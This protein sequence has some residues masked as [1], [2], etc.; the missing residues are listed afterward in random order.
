LL[1]QNKSVTDNA[2]TFIKFEMNFSF[3][4]TTL[5]ALISFVTSQTKA[6]VFVY[7]D[8]LAGDYLPH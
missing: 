3:S 7:A 5:S 6:E 4:K 8:A 1:A 2:R